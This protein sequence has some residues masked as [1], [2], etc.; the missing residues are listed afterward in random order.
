MTLT[1][2]L[3]AA[4][5]A[6]LLVSTAAA[7]VSFDQI[8]GAE[9]GG[10]LKAALDQGARTAVASLGQTDGFWS[11]PKVRIPLPEAI[12]RGKGVLKMMGRG[13]EVDELER[14][15]NRAAEQAVPQAQAL[16]LD[17]VKTMSVSDAK[18]ILSGGDDSVTQF[19]KGKT[20]VELARRF[21]P[22]VK[23]ITDRSG[24]A[25]QYNALAG[26]GAQFGLIKHEQASVEQYV[27]QKAL[28]GLYSTIGEQERA[29][30]ANPAAA[31]SDL[32]KKV[33]GALR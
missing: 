32:A 27:T 18:G 23:T 15:L 5:A 21:L 3:R 31:T 11:N 29:L 1:R 28:D 13:A 30:R 8:T 9:A 19:F 20:Q 4:L 14:G 25:Q 10:G 6:A 26:Q 24:L 7:A 17:A 16:L 33:F 2:S 12:A 22:V